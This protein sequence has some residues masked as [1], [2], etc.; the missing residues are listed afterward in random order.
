MS[1]EKLLIVK[2]SEGQINENEARIPLCDLI[3]LEVLL[4]VSHQNIIGLVV[5]DVLG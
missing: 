5:R 4:Y 3:E 1:L 2:D